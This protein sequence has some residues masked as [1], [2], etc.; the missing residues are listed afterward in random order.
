[1]CIASLCVVFRGSFLYIFNYQIE[2]LL[3]DVDFRVKVT[4]KE[5]EELCEDI[6]VRIGDPVTQALQVA[7]ITL[8]SIIISYVYMSGGGGGGGL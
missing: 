7:D 4:R 5:L 2:G 6:F 8:V 1:M 3:E